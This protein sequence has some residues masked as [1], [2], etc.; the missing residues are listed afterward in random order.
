MS[1]KFTNELANKLKNGVQQ[2]TVPKQQAP[3]VEA[4]YEQPRYTPPVYTAP[5]YEP[6]KI[7][8]PV[9]DPFLEGFYEDEIKAGLFD[10]SKLYV[11]P[12]EAPKLEEYHKA[13]AP[14]VAPL[15]Y[16]ETDYNALLQSV[17]QEL[18]L[19]PPVQVTN[20]APVWGHE[21]FLEGFN[22]VDADN[23]PAPKNTLTSKASDSIFR[24]EEPVFAWQEQASNK[25][26]ETVRD[27]AFLEGFL[28]DEYEEYK[29]R[30]QSN[31]LSQ[32]G[33]TPIQ[34]I[35]WRT[36]SAATMH[37]DIAQVAA[38]A[39]ARV[40]NGLSS[41]KA[42]L[43]IWVYTYCR[44]NEV[45]TGIDASV[46]TAIILAEMGWSPVENMLGENN[47][48]NFRGSGEDSWYA[49][50]TV[51]EAHEQFERNWNSWYRFNNYYNN[52]I[53]ENMDTQRATAY[54]IYDGNWN[55]Q[56]FS[57]AEEFYEYL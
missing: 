9:K 17:R 2:P 26:S 43:V 10:E 53:G 11:K 23:V 6:P 8:P 19:T 34:I 14:Q 1:N 41:E 15:Q 50:D 28:G 27:E 42:E 55:K 38:N 54:A 16:L 5:K 31:S 29:V 48:Y 40:E 25:L 37:S 49:F 7:T 3:V 36:A 46:R 39:Y 52:I 57:S 21:A 32:K 45:E 56:D 4:K 18:N 33:F 13:P 22:S 12:Y 24:R 35:A 51:E 20:N 30:E 44:T 47:I